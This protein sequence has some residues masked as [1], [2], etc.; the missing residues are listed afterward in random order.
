MKR[1]LWLQRGGR[2]PRNRGK[3]TREGRLLILEEVTG[4]RR[5]L[6]SE[7][8]TRKQI[9]ENQKVKGGK[10]SGGY[11]YQLYNYNEETEA[12]FKQSTHVPWF[13]N[14]NAGLLMQRGLPQDQENES[15]AAEKG[16]EGN[17]AVVKAGK[18]RS[19]EHR[20]GNFS[21]TRPTTRRGTRRSVE[22]PGRGVGVGVASVAH[23]VLVLEH[24]RASGCSRTDQWSPN[25]SAPR[26]PGGTV[27]T[28]GSRPPSR[29]V[30]P[31][32]GA[33]QGVLLLL[34][35]WDTGSSLKHRGAGDQQ[36]C[37]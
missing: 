37:R 4:P 23:E 8:R 9:P 25:Q 29:M 32:G 16:G 15:Q 19:R 5:G 33:V 34:L 7:T 28:V 1:C 10:A 24:A 6:C 26:S 14:S 35:Y 13:I 36:P 30:G 31:L 21:R 12:E 2:A 18:E 22:G 17:R 3:D 27:F 20:A 11:Y